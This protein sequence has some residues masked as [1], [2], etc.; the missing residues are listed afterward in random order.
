[1]FSLCFSLPS[2][3]GIFASLWVKHC[4]ATNCILST[5]SGKKSKAPNMVIILKKKIIVCFLLRILRFWNAK[6]NVY[7]W[8]AVLDLFWSISILKHE[9]IMSNYPSKQNNIKN[10][11]RY[12]KRLICGLPQTW[13]KTILNIFRRKKNT[14]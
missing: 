2:V 8:Y 10:A 12:G 13:S 4:L 6:V 3:Q 14:Y 1:M 9:N 11:K 7:I 5:S